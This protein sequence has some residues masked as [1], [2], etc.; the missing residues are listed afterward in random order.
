[1][2]LSFVLV[3]L[4]SL[5]L[6]SA[7][8]LISNLQETKSAQSYLTDNE[9]NCTNISNPAEIRRSYIKPNGGNRGLFGQHTVQLLDGT[10]CSDGLVDALDLHHTLH[11]PAITE[12]E[13]EIITTLAIS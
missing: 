2:N 3:V 7:R 6:L 11:G 1:M 13:G 12:K 10:A 8:Q 5:R 9:T 4:D